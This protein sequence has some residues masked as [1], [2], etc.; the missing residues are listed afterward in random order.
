MRVVLARVATASVTMN[1]ETIG[2][3]ETGYLLL[4]GFTHTDT[5]V[6][7]GKMAQKIATLR[8]MEDEAGKM[9]RTIS[10]TGGQVLAV[11]Q[12]TLYADTSGRRPGFLAAARPEVASPLFDKFVEQLQAESLTVKTGSFGS[13]MIVESQNEG[14]LTLLLEN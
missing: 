14:P 8:I 9:N 3:I 2:S 6:N 12:F 4:V 7:T 5:E 10:E 1:K 13:F 11:P